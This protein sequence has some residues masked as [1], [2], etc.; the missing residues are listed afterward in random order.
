M[1]DDFDPDEDMTADEIQTAWGRG[2]PVTLEG[3]SAILGLRS[4]RF[5][6]HKEDGRWWYDSPDLPGHYGAAATR[7]ES[8][9]LADEAVGVAGL[10][11]AAVVHM[12]GPM[13]EMGVVG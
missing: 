13:V 2:Q 4:V 9:R 5:H 11:P 12:W 7:D 1:S 10:A 8:I 6:H 3:A